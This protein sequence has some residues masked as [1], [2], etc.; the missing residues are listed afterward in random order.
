MYSNFAIHAPQSN[1]Y[2]FKSHDHFHVHFHVHMSCKYCVMCHVNKYINKCTRQT[3]LIVQLLYFNE[4]L[5]W[6]LLATSCLHSLKYPFKSSMN[7]VYAYVLNHR[8]FQLFNETYLN[9]ET[10]HLRK[11]MI[12]QLLLQTLL[13]V[14]T[15]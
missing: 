9:Y 1:L 14:S 2:D 5:Y 11:R 15:A 3:S 4:L 10:Q 6:P 13:T 12:M 8:I 7:I